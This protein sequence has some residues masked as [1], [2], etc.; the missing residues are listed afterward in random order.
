M[1][2][3]KKSRSVNKKPDCEFETSKIEISKT[4]GHIVENMENLKNKIAKFIF[5]FL[6]L[7][8]MYVSNF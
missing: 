1:D 8:E 4:K 3:F 6:N 7:K 2:Y 5:F